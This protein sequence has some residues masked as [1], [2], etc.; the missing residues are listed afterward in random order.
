MSHSDRSTVEALI[1]AVLD[2]LNAGD[3]GKSLNF[4]TD[5]EPDAANLDRPY[6]LIY[7]A[8][9]SRIS[10]GSQGGESSTF[11]GVNEWVLNLVVTVGIPKMGQTTSPLMYQVDDYI[12]NIVLDFEDTPIGVDELPE[13][14]EWVSMTVANVE[15]GEDQ[16]EA[17]VVDVMRMQLD[18]LYNKTRE[19]V[20]R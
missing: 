11:Q 19:N 16:E 13:D 20:V 12:D 4:F 3:L 1:Q 7:P 2:T 17:L 14:I 18:I 9:R 15:F 10:G 6:V 5:D 8:S